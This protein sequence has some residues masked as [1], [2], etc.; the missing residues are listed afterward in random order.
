MI[1]MERRALVVITNLSGYL[2]FTL[3]F[4]LENLKIFWHKVTK[5]QLLIAN[6]C[7]GTELWSTFYDLKKSYKLKQ[8]S[9]EGSRQARRRLKPT[10]QNL[11]RFNRCKHGRI[12]T[13]MRTKL[14]WQNLWPRDSET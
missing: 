3:L 10:K 4:S 6:T 2:L 13:R 7:L 11:S 5:I 8:R 1:M 12:C 14:R 9:L